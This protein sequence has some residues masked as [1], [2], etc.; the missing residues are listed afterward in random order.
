MLRLNTLKSHS[1]SVIVRL[2]RLGRSG[3]KIPEIGMGSW[4]MGTKPEDGI[5]AIRKGISLGM[6]FIDTAEMYANEELVGAAIRGQG[7]VFI[8]TKVSPNHLRRADLIKACKRSLSKLGVKSIDLY[9]VHWPNPSV[10]IWETMSAMEHLVDAGLVRHIG[11]SNFSVGE[12]EAARAAMKRYD[13]V[14]LETE[15]SIL[16]R[17]MERDMLPYCRRE[18]ITVI[19]YSPLARGLI[20]RG[21]QAALQSALRSVA[22]RHHRTPMQAALNWVV[23]NDGVVAIP[24]ASDPSHMEEDA[25]ASGWRM[26]ARERKDISDAAVPKPPITAGN[27]P[28]ITK[29]ASLTGAYE[30]IQAFK[31]RRIRGAIK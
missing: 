14:S 16:V 13:I 28:F 31:N 10:D 30:R 7:P 3:E 21:D 18:G 5:R 15:Y 23:A 22:A 6:G 12:M 1:K 26:S 25:G 27:K 2:K 24:K 8:A 17:G 4:K 20:L 9:M 19:A 11:V 29:F